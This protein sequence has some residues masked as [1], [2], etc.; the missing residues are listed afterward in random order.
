MHLPPWCSARVRVTGPRKRRAAQYT[1]PSSKRKR[2]FP[3]CFQGVWLRIE[4]S[5]DWVS[6]SMTRGQLVQS[7]TAY[8]GLFL[9]LGAGR[10][11]RRRAARRGAQDR[12][13]ELRQHRRISRV[14]VGQPLRS[15]RS[16]ASATQ[17]PSRMAP[18]ASIAGHQPSL[19]L[20]V[21]T[22]A[23]TRASTGRPKEN[24]TPALR[25]AAAKVW[26][27]R[28]NHSAPESVAP[29]DRAGPDGRGRQRLQRPPQHGDVVG[30][31]VGAGV[32]RSQQPGQRFPAGDLGAVQ[33]HQQRVMAPGLLPGRGRFLL[34]M[35]VIDG[36]GGID[37]QVQP[38]VRVGCR[39]R[40]P[41]HLPGVGTCSPDTGQ[42]RRVDP[43]VD[44][45][46]HRG[47]G[48][49]GTEDMFTIPAAL[50]TPSMQ[51]APAASA[52]AKSGSYTH[53]PQ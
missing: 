21:S 42:M 7:S 6:C 8:I 24:P 53:G 38:L 35:G 26:G 22:A 29:R 23:C 25:H 2:R 17:A 11:H 18:S 20:S 27:R 3:S 15:T 46:P 1:G 48:R 44:Q 41:R 43:G 52:A 47:R 40:R 51:S 13:G 12:A 4:P 33:K 49:R 5:E 31:G 45:P 36:D 9:S 14:P 30:G 10:H 34:A 39:T 19:S 32:A 37:I 28:R 16:V 50:P